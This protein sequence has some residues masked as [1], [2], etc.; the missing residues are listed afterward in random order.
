MEESLNVLAKEHHELEQ[1]VA[2]HLS[3]MGTVPR[4]L[5]HKSPR[6]YDTDDDEFHDAFEIDSDTDTLLTANNSIFNSPANSIQELNLMNSQSSP[7]F[8]N[9]NQ[10][11]TSRKVRR[12][13]SDSNSSSGSSD[14]LVDG[15]NSIVSVASSCGTYVSQG[16]NAYKCARTELKKRKDKSDSVQIFKNR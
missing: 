11:Y 7:Y 2:S 9:Y 15:E 8:S 16:G 6:F 3:E 1:S 4:S 12:K 14:T 10:S 13:S 5:S